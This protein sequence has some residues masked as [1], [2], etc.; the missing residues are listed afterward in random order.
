MQVVLNGL[1]SGCL[2][3]LLATAFSIAYLPTRILHLALA[4]VFAMAPYIAATAL[5]MGWP[6]WLAGLAAVVVCATV[7]LLCESLNHWRLHIQGAPHAV[8]LISSL[9]I[10]IV[11]VQGIAMLWG[12]DPLTLRPGMDEVY[13]FHTLMLTRS[14]GVA[15]LVSLGL[16][17]GFHLWLRHSDLGLRFRGMADDPVEMAVLGHNVRRLRALAFFVSGAM[18]AAT[19]LAVALDLGFSPHTGLHMLML[20][21]VAS[22]V[23]GRG[24]FAGAVLGGL[25][26]GV[27]RAE[28]AWHLSAQWQEAVTFLLLAL[29]LVLRPQ[30]ILGRRQRLEVD[31]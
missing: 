19:S 17:A 14:Q 23:G 28:V 7:S 5:G 9:G 4:A 26:I 18:A 29:F 15:L 21:I 11:L 1:V 6:W 27:L 24:A 16:L 31:G 25:L 12:N 13:R 20:A 10:M 22:I 8:H 3:A 2:L 30:G